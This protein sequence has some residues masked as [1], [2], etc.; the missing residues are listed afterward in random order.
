MIA[1][2]AWFSMFYFMIETVRKRRSGVRLW[3][4]A[5][6][7]NPFSHVFA[8]KNLTAQGLVSRRRLVFSLAAFLLSI[9]VGLAIGAATGTLR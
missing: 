9:G 7:L 1:V 6:L 4:D 3:R 2:A 5:P 8:G